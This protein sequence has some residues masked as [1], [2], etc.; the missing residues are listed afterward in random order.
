MRRSIK[1][2]PSPLSK[3]ESKSST[4]KCIKV[5]VSFKVKAVEVWRVDV[6]AAGM[7]GPSCCKL[8]EAPCALRNLRG[9]A[10]EGRR[11]RA[12]VEVAQSRGGC[13][14][15]HQQTHCPNCT[16]IAAVAMA[17]TIRHAMRRGHRD[18]TQRPPGSTG[19]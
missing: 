11:G 18:I 5:R 15:A 3:L 4:V 12:G 6:L 10:G 13:C 8:R 9:S 19:C 17:K 7:E 14:P 1:L 2:L 16:G